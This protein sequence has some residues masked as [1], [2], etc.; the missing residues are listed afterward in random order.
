VGVFELVYEMNNIKFFNKLPSADANYK[1]Y[2]LEKPLTNVDFNN[3]FYLQNSVDV[4]KEAKKSYT[5][6][7]LEKINKDYFGC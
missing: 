1:I 5:K 3:H 4:F 2:D 6:K 7:E